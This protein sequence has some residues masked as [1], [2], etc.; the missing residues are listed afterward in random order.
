MQNTCSR[1]IFMVPFRIPKIWQTENCKFFN[2]T[3][4]YSNRF[5]SNRND[6]LIIRRT[7]EWRI[8]DR[9]CK[10]QC[11]KMPVLAPKKPKG[12]NFWICFCNFSLPVA[13][14]LSVWTLE[15]AFFIRCRVQK[16]RKQI[17]ARLVRASKK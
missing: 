11:Q 2:F 4:V 7:I 13:T 3:H 8:R 12:K 14:H 6:S 5:L 1:N 16:L 15:A 10:I 17:W 9:Q